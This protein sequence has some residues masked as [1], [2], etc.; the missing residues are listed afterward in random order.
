ME[1]VHARFEIAD[2]KSA[3]GGGAAAVTS[4]SRRGRNSSR[5]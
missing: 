3:G 1:T 2:N 5:M 4:E